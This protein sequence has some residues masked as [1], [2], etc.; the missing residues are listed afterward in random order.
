MAQNTFDKEYRKAE[1]MY[2]LNKQVEIKTINTSDPR[3]FWQ[4]LKS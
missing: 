1:R 4:S 2:K 3:K